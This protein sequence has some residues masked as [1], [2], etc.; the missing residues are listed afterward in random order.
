MKNFCF[1][2]F[3]CLGAYLILAAS[4][5][6]EDQARVDADQMLSLFDRQVQ[7]YA[8]YQKEF[9]LENKQAFKNSG[10]WKEACKNQR[11]HA[12]E[13]QR[14]KKEFLQF[15]D[16]FVQFLTSMN[17][18][19]PYNR[20]LIAHA[21]NQ[22]TKEYIQLVQDCVFPVRWELLYEEYLKKENKFQCGS[23]SGS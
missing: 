7:W 9:L 8:D 18:P 22:I 13:I 12:K 15:R 23:S 4:K 16:R 10:E 17:C 19:A 1:R 3:F 21:R 14:S 2:L 5:M 11:K 6:P 20:M